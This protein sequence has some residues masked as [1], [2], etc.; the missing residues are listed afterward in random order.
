ML[1]K[2]Q[3]STT[4]CNITKRVVR[5]N[6]LQACKTA[7]IDANTPGSDQKENF[8]I[9]GSGVAEN[10][11][12]ITHIKI[13]HGFDIGAAKQPHGCKNSHHSHD[14]EEVFFVHKGNW[15]FT[16][17]ETGNDGEIIL[18]EGD[19]ISLPTNMFRGF[20]NVGADDGFLLSVLGVNQNGSA[21]KLIWAPYVIEQAQK[22]GLVLLENGTLIDT[23]KGV[24]IPKG[25]KITKPLSQEEL[26]HFDHYTK[27]D[28]RSTIC[29][30]NEISTLPKS[31]GLNHIKGVSEQVIIGVN[32]IN[33]GMQAGKINTP[34]Q[35]SVRKIT[36][37]ALATTGM[38]IRSEEEVIFIHS[39]QIHVMTKHGEFTLNTGDFFTCPIG[40]ERSYSNTSEHNAELIVIR[41]G[42]YP[43]A[44]KFIS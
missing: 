7:F 24:R 43:Q 14:T 1:N 20:E 32:N 8:C 38:H 6:E 23:T 5:Y 26:S 27:D 35:F 31:G 42:D 25:A 22:H 16:W 29:L 9:I 21:G 2:N 13:P 40:L 33:E 12:Q 36:L 30:N 39:G 18:S 37:S 11:D 4:K 44:A 34:H 3:T 10:P 17:G 19:T 15:K 28:M 41:R